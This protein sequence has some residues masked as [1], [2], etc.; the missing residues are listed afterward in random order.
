MQIALLGYGKMGQTIERLAL[1][2]GH[3]IIAKVDTMEDF[4]TNLTNIG[5]ADV[6]IEFTTPESAPHN[7]LLCAE[8][9]IPVVSGTTGWL[10]EKPNIE[11]EFSKRSGA[12]FYA[13]NYSLGVNIFFA[14]NEF[15]AK[16]MSKFEGYTPSLKEIHHIHK[17]DSPSGTALTLTQPILAHNKHFSSWSLEQNEM[18]SL[19]IEALRTD[20]V[21]GTH[22]VKYRSAS[23]QIEI[24]HEAYTRDSF[25]A[26]AL[27]AAEWLPGKNGIFGMKDLLNI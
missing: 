17:L 19:Y 24:T 12:F 20:E 18:D 10:S 8:H 13:S 22:S 9:G 3:S 2:K 14:L 23:D 16:T 4:I 21:P 7:L 15:L 27:M 1:A 6:A 26:G 25:A 11:E 5:R